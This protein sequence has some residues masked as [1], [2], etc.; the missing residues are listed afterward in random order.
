MDYE[1]IVIG[2]GP[3]GIAAAIQLTRYQIN[4]LL[5]E[6]N[7]IGGLVRNAYLVENYPGFPSGINGESLSNLLHQ[8][9]KKIGVPVCFEEVTSLDYQDNLFIVE[10]NNRALTSRIVIIATGT[11]P[12]K[13]PE[14]V[15]SKDLIGKKFFYEIMH[16]KDVSNRDILVVGNGDAAFDYALSLSD[17]GNKVIIASRSSKPKCIPI[18]EERCFERSS[19]EYYPNTVITSIRK[20]ENHLLVT[21]STSKVFTVDYVVA[22]IGRKPCLGFLSPTVRRDL[23]K[24]CEEQKLYLAGDVKNGRL[25][26]VAIS[27]GDGVRAAMEIIR[28]RI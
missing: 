5:L 21:S 25:R 2:G 1:V 15:V 9:I 20:V 4:T 27:V 8:H 14:G 13:L 3:A 6:K 26:Q 10:T 24:L 11:I 7:K 19:I 22:A 28:K 16:L 23:E 12:K 18:L 17:K